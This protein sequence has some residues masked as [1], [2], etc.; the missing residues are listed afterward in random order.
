MTWNPRDVSG[1]SSAEKVRSVSEMP[2]LIY[3]LGR[4][5]RRV[6]LAQGVFDL[7]HLGH[8]KYLEE[9]ARHG[10]V[11]V[12]VESDEAVRLNKG[13]TRPIHTQHER[14]LAVASFSSVGLVFGYEDALAY[15]NPEPYVARYR[16]L[17]ADVAIPAWDPNAQLKVGQAREAGVGIVPI[18][19]Q[20]VAN[21]TTRLLGMLGYLE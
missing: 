15:D 1:L 16:M 9:S 20:P 2:G 18:M 6:V 7:L 14:M 11:V 10:L 5:G 12:G 8:I 13:S 21:S 17:N 3:D 19:E 4:V